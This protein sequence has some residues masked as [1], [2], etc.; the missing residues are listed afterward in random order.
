M[1]GIKGQYLCGSDMYVINVRSYLAN[2]CLVL[3][4]CHRRNQFIGHPRHMLHI[5][6]RYTCTCVNV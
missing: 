3:Q 2:N 5:G 4:I 6:R 1:K